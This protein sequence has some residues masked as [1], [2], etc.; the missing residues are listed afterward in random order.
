MISEKIIIRNEV[1]LHA[2]PASEFVRIAEKFSSS[3]R[4]CKDGIWVNGKSILA[5]LTLAAEKGSEVILEVK[6]KDEEKAFKALKAVL[7]GA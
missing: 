5:I 2:R 6:G 7:L 4:L 1:G 3:V